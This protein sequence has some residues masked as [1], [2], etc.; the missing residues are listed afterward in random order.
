MIRSALAW[1]LALALLMGAVPAHAEPT[2][3][4]RRVQKLKILVLAGHQV[5]LARVGVMVFANK[6]SQVAAPDLA[7]TEATYRTVQGLLAPE[8]NLQVQRVDVPAEAFARLAAL[9]MAS[10]NGLAPLEAELLPYR[11]DCACDAL[12]VITPGQGQLNPNSNQFFK[13]FTWIGVGGFSGESVRSSAA[14]SYLDLHLVD[15]INGVVDPPRPLLKGIVGADPREPMPADSWPLPMQGLDAGQ[16]STLN[17]ALARN[18]RKAFRRTLYEMGL[19]P[20]CAAYFQNLDG[21]LFAADPAQRLF[22]P[23]E[24]PTANATCD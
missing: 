21:K 8:K 10:S 9:A 7:L 4:A 2:E 14:A 13:G 18:M 15:A 19:K 16:W 6:R 24:Q 17:A 22:P 20:S 1:A 12:L 11:Q 5:E 23:A 3:L